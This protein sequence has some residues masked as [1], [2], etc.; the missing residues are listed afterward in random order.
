[1]I[2]H[3][4]MRLLLP[5]FEDLFAVICS[6]NQ[7]KNGNP[8]DAD[9]KYKLDRYDVQMKKAS[10]A[11]NRY[12]SKLK[13]EFS[14]ILTYHPI[15]DCE[16]G[17]YLLINSASDSQTP[18]G[19][20]S[21]LYWYLGVLNIAHKLNL[22]VVNFDWTAAHVNDE[23]NADRE[24][25]WQ[26]FH[27]HIPSSAYDEC[28]ENSSI[29]QNIFKYD[30]LGNQTFDQ[31]HHGKQPFTIKSHFKTKLD[32]FIANLPE[33]NTGFTFY[34]N[35][36]FTITSS[37]MEIGV[38][39]EI[40]WWLQHRKLYNEHNGVWSGVRVPSNYQ[41]TDYFQYITSNMVKTNKNNRID[42]FQ[43]I[44]CSSINVHDVL[45]IGV[46]IRRGDIV[47][48]DSQRHIIS[49]MLYRYIANSAYVP[50]LVSIIN[51]LPIPIR[52]KYLITIYSEG[53]IHDFQ[54]ILIDLKSTL[55]KSRCR[56]SFFLNGR[57][58]ETF[59]RLVRDDIVIGTVSTFSL[60]TGIFNS[61]QLK[62]GPYHNRRR[63]H[64]MRNY[65]RLDRDKNHTKFIFT[66]AKQ[67]LIKQRIQYVWKQK[68]AQ[69]KTP[70][71]L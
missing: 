44:Q 10:K 62:L 31:Y 2:Y 42:V 69:Q 15:I 11:L 14:I 36:T 34:S 8:L 56:V 7:D 58:S 13:S 1:M 71:P 60:A 37:L 46:H 35:R 50:L 23:T 63:A 21:K 22:T 27:W 59:N 43:P 16:H 48:Q 29:K 3:L 70:I 55:P 18:D 67:K 47:K 66:K 17:R 20:G 33:K 28:P 52:N 4:F 25:Y 64:G 45:L 38:I 53:T 65:L 26:F 57:T 54:D 30:L 41:P 51:S 32:D 68:K 61:R 6:Q 40:R 49:S 39:F 24:K 5:I 19:T 12:F 9:L